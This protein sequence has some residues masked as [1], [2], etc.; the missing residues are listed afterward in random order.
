MCWA[1]TGRCSTESIMLKNKFYASA[2]TIAMVD[3]R[4][5]SSAVTIEN[6]ESDGRLQDSQC[7]FSAVT[8]ETVDAG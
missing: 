8:V 3:C 6:L 7:N 5:N 2:V 1:D 4:I